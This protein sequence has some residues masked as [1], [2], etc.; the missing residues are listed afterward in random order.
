ML[1]DFGNDVL[2]G[3]PVTKQLVMTNHTTIPAPFSLEAEYFIGCPPTP[4][5]SETEHRYSA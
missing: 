2:L 5:I 1:L 3:T 4:N